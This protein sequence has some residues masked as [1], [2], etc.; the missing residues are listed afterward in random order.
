[1][2]L[3]NSFGPNP[4][5]VRMFLAEK[6]MTL[7]SEDLDLLAG[8]KQ[9]GLTSW[10]RSLRAAINDL[11]PV[12]DSGVEHVIEMLG[13]VGTPTLQHEAAQGV[14]Q[15]AA[16]GRRQLALG[17]AFGAV[18]LVDGLVLG[19]QAFVGAQARPKLGHARQCFAVGRTQLRRVCHAVQV[20]D[21]TPCAAQAFSGHIQYRGHARPLGRKVGGGDLL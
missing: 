17:D 20:A 5:L 6:G 16:A 15:G 1:M 3:L 8:A 14:V 12:P 21:G 13:D 10:S 7:P 4:R 9:V 18:L 19:V 2:K 11:L